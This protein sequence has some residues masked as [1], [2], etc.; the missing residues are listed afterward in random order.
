MNLRKRL[1]DLAEI[2]TRFENVSTCSKNYLF[3]KWNTTNCHSSIP[4]HLHIHPAL[5][6][7]KL[8][9]VK[10]FILPKPG[11]TPLSAR[12][13]RLHS[14]QCL[15]SRSLNMSL[16]ILTREWCLYLQISVKNP[17]RDVLKDRWGLEFQPSTCHYKSPMIG[18]PPWKFPRIIS[19]LRLWQEGKRFVFLGSF[20]VRNGSY[21][22]NKNVKW[23]PSQS[24]HRRDVAI[25]IFYELSGNVVPILL[26]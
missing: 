1:D 6:K 26:F 5:H 13:Q 18:F 3:K 23:G 15:F 4:L 20:M 12:V 9:N 24:R 17:N 16:W 7:L 14:P 11:S 22:S 2:N 21:L 19:V 10:I 8:G 25:S